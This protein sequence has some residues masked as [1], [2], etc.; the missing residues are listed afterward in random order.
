MLQKNSRKMQSKLYYSFLPG[1]RGPRKSRGEDA[2]GDCLF[3]LEQ[4]V[5]KRKRKEKKCTYFQNSAF[6]LHSL[7]TTGFY[8]ESHFLPQT[9]QLL[10]LF[11]KNHDM[12][13]VF[14]FFPYMFFQVTV[15]FPSSQHFLPLASTGEHIHFSSKR[16]WN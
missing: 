9:F 14:S 15:N 6:S 2:V 10:N 16:C 5:F 13:F 3:L 1:F 7:P 11:H 8:S 12:C 4:A